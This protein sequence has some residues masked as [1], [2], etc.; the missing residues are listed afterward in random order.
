MKKKR[1]EEE[2]KNRGQHPLEQVDKLVGPVLDC[3]AIL[4]LMVSRSEALD[5]DSSM[6]DLIVDERM[7]E[8]M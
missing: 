3:G 4:R 8:S 7:N 6:P 1:W 2:K 5:R